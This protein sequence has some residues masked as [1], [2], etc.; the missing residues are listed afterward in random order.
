MLCQISVN[1]L[2]YP[3]PWI[4]ADRGSHH[5]FCWS[6]YPFRKS[7][8]KHLNVNHQR[9]IRSL[10]N[11]LTQF[12][13]THTHTEQKAL[14]SSSVNKFRAIQVPSQSSEDH[15]H[16]NN[17]GVESTGEDVDVQTAH[18]HHIQIL[19]RLK[20]RK[21]QSLK[22]HTTIRWKKEEKMRKLQNSFHLVSSFYFI[23]KSFIL[24]QKQQR[25][26]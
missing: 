8:K 1:I 17:P 7:S 5:Q 13:H 4:N 12:L 25:K 10:Y 15:H 6:P 23:S 24:D 3:Y 20:V 21:E 16:T 2:C 22:K 11:T 19:S 9:K 26:P 18:A 14:F